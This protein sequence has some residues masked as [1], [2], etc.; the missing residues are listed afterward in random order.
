MRRSVIVASAAL[1]A[2][3]TLMACGSGGGSA[4]PAGS[5]GGVAASAPSPSCV[6]QYRVWSSGPAHAAGENLTAALNIL[7][8][9]SSASDIGAT[10]AALK[11][12]GVAARTLAQS[13]IPACA[14]P[15]GYWRAVLVGIQDAA[16]NAGTSQGQGALTAAGV[17]LKRM[18]VLERK[19]AAELRRTVP[20]LGQNT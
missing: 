5:G 4:A 10:S 6:Q 11:R 3:L 7:Q 8:A 2:G 12:A 15:R 20:G 17:A 18:P 16:D 9:A 14:D 13:P 1:A 19:L